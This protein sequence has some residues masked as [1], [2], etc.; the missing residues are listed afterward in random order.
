MKCIFDVH[1]VTY[2]TWYY[3]I[4]IVLM[5]ADITFFVPFR[6]SNK[7]NKFKNEK[8]TRLNKL[9]DL[10]VLLKKGNLKEQNII[11]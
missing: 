3:Y 4:I 11:Y 7:R 6:L 2:I 9:I 5:D 1:D 10:L 8:L